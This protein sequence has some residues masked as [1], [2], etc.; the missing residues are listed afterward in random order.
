MALR[1]RCLDCRAFAPIGRNR[2]DEHDRVKRAERRQGRTGPS[3][4]LRKRLNDKGFS[5]CRECE[6]TMSAA[7]LRVDHIVPLADGG[8]DEWGNLNV[9]CTDCHN[10]KSAREARER[11]AR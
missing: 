1:V 9:L 8:K 2:C 4:V 6:R 11:A 7:L 5:H 10:K 3:L